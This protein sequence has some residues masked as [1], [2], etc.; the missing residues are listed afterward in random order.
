ME[1]DVD[2][3]G[4]LREEDIKSFIKVI[5]RVLEAGRRS[6]WDKRIN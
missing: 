4:C 6:L 1:A 2:G 5:Q 3:H